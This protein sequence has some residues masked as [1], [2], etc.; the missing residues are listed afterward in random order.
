MN[1]REIQKK[2]S[3]YR[4]KESDAATSAGIFAHIAECKICR[5][6]SE[7]FRETDDLLKS[8]PKYEMQP[9]FAAHTVLKLQASLTAREPS[10]IARVFRAVQTFFEVFEPL[11][12][13][14]SP[15]D[16]LRDFPPFSMAY[17]YL[18]KL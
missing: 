5:E 7:S 1:C 14:D 12:P 8:L 6:E 13:L 10:L 2:I 18:K 9:E 11:K 17:I 4:D 16:E 3:A 15:L